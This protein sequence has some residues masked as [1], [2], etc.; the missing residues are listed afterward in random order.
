MAQHCCW[1][2]STRNNTA[3]F[4]SASSVMHSWMTHQGA[5]SCPPCNTLSRCKPAFLST[6]LHLGH[7][8]ASCRTS[9]VLVLLSTARQTCNCR[10]A[11]LLFCRQGLH[12]SAINVLFCTGQNRCES[13]WRLKS[14]DGKHT[15]PEQML[16]RCARGSS[17]SS[18]QIR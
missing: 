3:L 7:L 14:P 16:F 10:P 5:G 9:L 15:R 4:N 8:L 12:Q 6:C 18:R 1:K 13:I 11:K 2:Q 17:C